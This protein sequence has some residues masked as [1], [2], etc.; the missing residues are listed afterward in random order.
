VLAA[1]PYL[2]TMHD[3]GMLMRR[4]GLRRPEVYTILG[5]ARA[6]RVSFGVV[7][8]L[9]EHCVQH[10]V[11]IALS[12]GNRACVQSHRGTI[13]HL[14]HPAGW[15]NL[16][17]PSAFI[18]IDPRAVHSTW[19]VQRPCVGGTHFQL[20]LL[21]PGGD[22]LGSIRS[23][24]TERQSEDWRWRRAVNSH[25]REARKHPRPHR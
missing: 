12:M 22:L 24:R 7:R 13:D 20:E 15:L 11:P 14:S 6:E 10:E 5:P 18:H 21:G 23:A 3:F 8:A 2:K 4:H 1:W 25:L 19:M 9:L 16:R 17:D